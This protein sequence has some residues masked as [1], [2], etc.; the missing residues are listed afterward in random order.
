ML[1][2]TISELTKALELVQ[3]VGYTVK[4]QSPHSLALEILDTC[5]KQSDYCGVFP[6]S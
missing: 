6:R 3:L 1:E 5:I 2:I 4:E